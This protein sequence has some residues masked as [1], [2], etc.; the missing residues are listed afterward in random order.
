VK[1]AYLIGAPGAGKSTV[2]ATLRSFAAKQQLY[3]EP[4]PH[5]VTFRQGVVWCAE[6]GRVRE[7]FAGTDAL[8]MDIIDA[9]E[10]FVS[11]RPFRRFFAE[12]DR[13]ANDRFFDHVTEAGY[14]LAVFYLDTPRNL[15]EERRAKRAAVVGKAQDGT[16]IKGRESKVRALAERWQ[17]KPLD[18]S[19]SSIDNAAIIKMWLR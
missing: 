7:H 4:L 2:A 11:A 8:A 12:G 1:F 14:E 3:E 9:A 6:L 17:A 15:L 5:L 16:W 13:L 19:L 10:R 18:G